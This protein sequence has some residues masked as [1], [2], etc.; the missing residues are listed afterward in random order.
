MSRKL[1]LCAL[2]YALALTLSIQGSS[3][4]ADE[5][6]SAWLASHQNLRNLCWSL[7]HGDSSDLQMGL[8]YLYLFF[9]VRLF[10]AG[11]YALRAANIPF[12]LIFSFSLI[13]TSWTVFRSRIAW[14][15]PALLP[16]V[17]HYASEAR[18]YMAILAL[19][20]AAIA[21]L[22]GFIQTT[23][24][25]SR[26]FPWLCLACVLTGG[27]FH[28]LFLLVVPPMALMGFLA[29]RH[30]RGARHW[31]Y[32]VRPLRIFALPF[33]A[34]AAFFIFTFARGTAYDY[35]HPGLRQ[36]ASVFYELSGLSGSDPTASFRSISGLIWCP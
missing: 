7:F 4:W 29:W 10:G 25:G 6:F 5:A 36:M 20:A 2:A 19:G 26:R 9:W 13:W 32:W 16:F 14:I 28:M 31:R 8:Y 11:E 1:I 21:S 35:P 27:L 17:W 30:M 12:T 24:P 3:L 18:P 15:A 23:G 33:C 22:L 34:E